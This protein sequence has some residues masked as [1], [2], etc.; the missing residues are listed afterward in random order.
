MVVISKCLGFSYFPLDR[1]KYG[2]SVRGVFIT[3][4]SKGGGSSVFEIFFVSSFS[5]REEE[6]Y[7]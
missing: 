7:G 6:I 3:N 1:K 2:S 5:L 4:Y